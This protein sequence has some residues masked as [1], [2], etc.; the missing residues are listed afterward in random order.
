MNCHVVFHR[1]STVLHSYQQCLSVPVS[2]YPTNT[3]YL[4]IITISGCEGYFWVRF[5]FAFLLWLVKLSIPSCAY[6]PF[7][8]S[9]CWNVSSDPLPIFKLV[10]VFLNW[11]LLA[12]REKCPH[13]L[14]SQKSSVLAVVVW[15]QMKNTA[16]STESNSM[17]FCTWS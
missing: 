13:F 1:S 14:G 12:G 6:W 11:C 17:L 9:L 16:F 7:V 15:E 5:W 10:L 3:C 8:Y 4:F 2:P